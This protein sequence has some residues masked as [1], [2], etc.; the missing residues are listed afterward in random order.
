MHTNGYWLFFFADAPTLSECYRTDAN[1]TS[2]TLSWQ[3]A[4]GAV[5][6][7]L[8]HD[9]GPPVSTS[10]T[11][12]VITGLEVDSTYSFNVTVHGLNATGNSVTCQ[13]STCM[14]IQ[15]FDF[16]LAL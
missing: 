15:L 1:T 16:F 5:Y 3:P 6:Y 2:L 12:A 11:S 4:A 14:S 10:D 9:S 8:A 7:T 13:A